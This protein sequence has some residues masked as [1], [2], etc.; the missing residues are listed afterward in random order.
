[1]GDETTIMHAK[2]VSKLFKFIAPAFVVLCSVLYWLGLFKNGDVNEFI[3]V[4]A[5]IY[6]A[7]AGTIDLNLFIKN[8]RGLE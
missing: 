4:G 7:G 3:K 8:V 6:A 2:D 5:F 1:M